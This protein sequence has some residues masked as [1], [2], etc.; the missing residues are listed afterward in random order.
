M[1]G[2]DGREGK[3]RSEEMKTREPKG[4]KFALIRHSYYPQSSSS[5]LLCRLAISKSHLVNL[6]TAISSFNLIT[7][8][9]SSLITAG[10]ILLF[11]AISGLFPG[12]H[13]RTLEPASTDS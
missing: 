7:A 11:P 10:G 9:I 8:E 5:I 6:F 2:I 1:K 4:C 3:Q 12:R 13:D